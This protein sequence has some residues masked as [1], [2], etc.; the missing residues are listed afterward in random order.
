MQYHPL[1]PLR[2]LDW[3]WQEARRGIPPKRE[4]RYADKSV[5]ALARWLA[6]HGTDPRTW[7]APKGPLTGLR[8]AALIESAGGVGR[9]ELRAWLV[10]G[11]DDA[12]IAQRLGLTAPAVTAFRPFF[13]DV[14]APSAIDAIL[15][16]GCRVAEWAQRPPTEAEIWIYLALAGGPHVLALVVAD[17]LGRP[18]PVV[19]DRAR[20]AGL[21]RAVVTSFAEGW[22]WPLAFTEVLAMA[23]L[24]LQSMAAR[25]VTPDSST[26]FHIH[27]LR[28]LGQTR[29]GQEPRSR[30]PTGTEPGSTITATRVAANAAATNRENMEVLHE[31][32]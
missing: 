2:P 23:D 22:R 7:P 15:P 28:S 16:R 4:L 25:G 10:S 17:H 27:H 18:E 31:R 26:R 1:N 6:R 30:P 8:E 13:F 21:L 11:V 20:T 19:P 5:V 3:R 12:A 9:D 29:P 32:D 14:G 24:M